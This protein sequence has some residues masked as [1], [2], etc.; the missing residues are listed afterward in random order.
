MPDVSNSIDSVSSSSPDAAPSAVPP[1]NLGRLWTGLATAQ[2]LLFFLA[3]LLA[4]LIWLPFYVGL[5]F[6]LVGGLLVGAATFRIARPSR[7]IGDKPLLIGA[8]TVG[9][10]TF[11]ITTFFECRN[12]ADTVADPPK[13]A[14]ARNAVVQSG[15]SLKDLESRAA[16]AFR[17]QLRSQYAPVDA[18]AYVFW[19]IAS[20]EMS[21]EVDGQKEK[22]TSDHAGWIW[23]LRAIAEILLVAAG[24]WSSLE[25]LRSA[26]PVSNLIG[27]DEEYEEE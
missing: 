18:I 1:A 13:F 27:L 26:T 9:V 7:P 12:F 11:C 23:P 22:I 6:F 14:A 16:D 4:R 15:A 17:R 19:T 20:G 2:L 24:L 3:P 5:F 25:A 21:L 10:I 8:L